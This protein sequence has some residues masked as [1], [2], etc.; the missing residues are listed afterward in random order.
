VVG[1]SAAVLAVAGVLAAWLCFPRGFAPPDFL[2]VCLSE[3]GDELPVRAWVRQDGEALRSLGWREQSTFA[4]QERDLVLGVLRDLAKREAGRPLVIYLNAIALPGPDGKLC[5]LPVDGRLDDPKGWI[6]LAQVF[7]YLRACRASHKLLLLDL[8]RPCTDPTKGLLIN[9][10]AQRLEAVLQSVLPQDPHLSVLCASAPGQ[11]SLTSEALGRSVFVHYVCRGLAGEADGHNAN[12]A[13]D[14]RVSLSEL[15]TF[16]GDRVDQWAMHYRGV[17]QTPRLNGSKEDFALAGAHAEAAT[18]PAAEP[19]LGAS[20]PEWLAAAWKERQAWWDA[21]V[22]RTEPTLFRRLESALLHA[23]HQWRGG[24]NAESAH[25]DLDARRKS[26]AEEY[27]ARKQPPPPAPNSLAKLLAREGKTDD[28][29]DRALVRDVQRLAARFAALAQAEKKDKEEEKRVEEDQKKLLKQLEKPAELAK[30]VFEAASEGPT[31]AASLRFLDDLLQ[32]GNAPPFAEV[33]FIG[34][35][36][37]L[38][39]TNLE[40]WPA[41][42]VQAAL[43]TVREAERSRATDS[44]AH[45]WVKLQCERAEGLRRAGEEMLFGKD[46]AARAGAREPLE[47]AMKAYQAI[48]RDLRTVKEAQ[49]TNDE[50]NVLLPGFAGYVEE[51]DAGEDAWR[52]AVATACRLRDLLSGPVSADERGREEQVRQMADW[53]DALRNDPKSLNKL[54]AALDK[55]NFERLIGRSSLADLADAKVMTA[56]LE[57]PWP[58]P[59]LR[60]ALWS[61]RME[62]IAALGSKRSDSGHLPAEDE[63]RGVAA[64]RQRALR[65]ARVA[66]ELLRLQKAPGLEKLEAA[67]QR[68]ASDPANADMHAFAEELRQ[69]W[70]LQ[71]GHTAG[72]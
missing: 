23:E 3:Y 19:A 66:V 54:R 30:V 70:R 67:L 64:E 13:R 14:G 63:G 49:N 48:N 29:P 35:L 20:Y 53:T 57:T 28:S 10:A 37:A 4:S 47:Q 71:R 43:L 65:R 15:A 40:E 44:S 62:L 58:S 34:R 2:P 24:V 51:D 72:Q 22:F 33:R 45:T 56:W 16:V 52:N 32:K 6:P 61:A 36:A 18:D 27:A 68:A 31:T 46:T 21:K 11:V 60:A 5:L 41:S 1:L 39:Q 26:I 17:R 25:K 12:G 7:D 9:D 55:E 38:A 8:M 50:A 59:T 42:S 69:A